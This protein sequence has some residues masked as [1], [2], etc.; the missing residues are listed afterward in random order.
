MDS[1]GLIFYRLHI[2]PDESAREGEDHDEWFRSLKAARRRR[3]ELIAENPE[4]E[5]HRYGEDFYIERVEI[6][7][8]PRL[9]LALV[10]LN[11]LG[12]IKQSKI[13]VE[14]YHPVGNKRHR[15]L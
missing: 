10:I 12:F 4:L 7:D 13:I 14:A 6:H 15:S 9:D 8:L 1:Q 2:A 5:S 3:D 11:R